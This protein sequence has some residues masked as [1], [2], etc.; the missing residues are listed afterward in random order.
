VWKMGRWASHARWG[1]G[2]CRHIMACRRVAASGGG[3]VCVRSRPAVPTPVD[4][5]DR[6]ARPVKRLL[7]QTLAPITTHRT[8]Y[9]C[10]GE[11]HACSGLQ[12]L[13]S[14]ARR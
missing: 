3:R 9:T 5:L 13:S 12:S 4:A 2:R 10:D 14:R 7:K 6:N 11:R 8:T 1:L